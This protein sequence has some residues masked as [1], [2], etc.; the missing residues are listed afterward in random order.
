[1]TG[2]TRAG[3]KHVNNRVHVAKPV[4][5]YCSAELVPA[6]ANLR[7][8]AEDR[9]YGTC[10][11]SQGKKGWL[12]IP[13]F[14]PFRAL[15]VQPPKDNGPASAL[16]RTQDSSTATWGRERNVRFAEALTYDERHSLDA[17]REGEA[18]RK[19]EEW[20]WDGIG[21]L[22]AVVHAQG[23]TMTSCRQRSGRE[24]PRAFQEL[25]GLLLL[26][27]AKIKWAVSAACDI[28][29]H[30]TYIFTVLT[31]LYV[32]VISG[33]RNVVVLDVYGVCVCTQYNQSRCPVRIPVIIVCGPWECSRLQASILRFPASHAVG[34]LGLHFLVGR[35]LNFLKAQR[36]VFSGPASGPA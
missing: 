21:S 35:R 11:S 10:I 13:G 8:L 25:R 24:A 7:L 16:N 14:R 36:C 6:S 33:G 23:K 20:D 9:E 26:R 1:M 2:T 34:N 5:R 18:Q 4:Y 19:Q 28:I 15:I 12:A 31:Y 22:R 27:A 29:R 30:I 17:D 32:R 3:S